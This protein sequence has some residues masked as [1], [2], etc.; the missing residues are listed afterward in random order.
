[1]SSVNQDSQIYEAEAIVQK[2]IR[3]RK[4]EYLIK[5]AGY[6]SRFNTWEPEQNIIDRRLIQ[7]FDDKRKKKRRAPTGLKRAEIPRKKS[8][9]VH[10]CKA[11]DDLQL[12]QSRQ[13]P[14]ESHAA[15]F[16]GVHHENSSKDD[17]STQSK[18]GEDEKANDMFDSDS[19]IDYKKVPPIMMNSSLINST[20]SVHRAIVQTAASNAAPSIW[21]RNKETA[22]SIFITDVTA[23]DCTV[24][25]REC[26]THEGF[27]TKPLMPELERLLA[28]T[29][30]SSAKD[31]LAVDST[32]DE[33]SWAT[34]SGIWR[35]R[36][37][38]AVA[39][40]FDDFSIFKPKQEPLVIDIS[41]DSK[42]APPK[43]Y[44]G[45]GTT[46]ISS[47]LGKTV[48]HIVRNP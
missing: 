27:F 4:T 5:W 10:Q 16:L 45:Q 41:E 23:N 13:T 33:G 11:I 47:W 24:T 17:I 9:H 7:T 48:H 39:N 36:D 42:D 35:R 20:S 31:Q 15:L 8:R 32:R 12:I 40:I 37:R 3:R 2:R 14:E 46:V 34:R 6:H 28:H 26:S 43:S 1:M 44:E 19:A 21:N 22:S 25:I 30:N 38:R 18:S 29:T